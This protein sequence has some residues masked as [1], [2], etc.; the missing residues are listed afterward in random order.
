MPPILGYWKIRGLVQPVR[1]ILKYTE[2]EFE[3]KWYEIAPDLS[4]ESWLK[5]KFTLGLEL[6]NLPY[7]IEGDIRMTQSRAI[8]RHVAREA[9]PSLLGTNDVEYRRIDMLENHTW[10]FW[11]SLI[12]LCFRYT[13]EDKC[14]FLRSLP[15]QLEL[16]S[17]FIGENKWS[18]S[19][20]LTYVDFMLYEALYQHKIFSSNCIV[21]FPKLQQFLENFEA[22]PQISAYFLSENYIHTPLYTRLARH[23]I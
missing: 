21:G 9:D 12:N 4:R 8:L 17:N 22:L 1:F 18:I 3:E 14:S 10:D 2:T 16:L 11:M 15:P 5:E 13:E 6:P 23:Y 7:F 20:N 19:D